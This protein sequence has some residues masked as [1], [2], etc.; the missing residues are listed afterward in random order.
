MFL[1]GVIILVVSLGVVL[2]LK[3][4]ETFTSTVDQPIIALSQC[5]RKMVFPNFSSTNLAAQRAVYDRYSM[6]SNISKGTCNIPMT[7]D[8]TQMNTSTFSVIND[9]NIFYSL[10]RTCLGLS[11]LSMN[12]SGDRVTFVFNTSNESDSKALMYFML[13]NPLF[14]DFSFGVG[15]TS[16]AYFPVFDNKVSRLNGE[17]LQQN[18]VFRYSNY[19]QPITSSMNP[20]VN[21]NNPSITFEVVLPSR[22]RGQ[23]SLFDYFDETNPYILVQDMNAKS[24]R[25][26]V[27]VQVYYL[28]DNIPTSYQNIGKTL[29]SIDSKYDMFNDIDLKNPNNGNEVLLFDKKYVSKYSNDDSRKAKYEFNNNIHVFFKN[30]Q[31]PSFTFSFDINVT[32]DKIR[33]QNFNNAMVILRAYMNNNY[34]NYSYCPGVGHELGGVRNN[35]IMMTLLEFGNKSNNGYNLVI[36]TGKGANCNYPSNEE[37]NLRIPLPYLDD[38][39][40][41]RVVF[42]LTPNEKIAAA[43]WKTIDENNTHVMLGK[44]TYCANDLNLGV[45]FTDKPRT[46]FSIE[47]IVLARNSNFVKSV[48]HVTLGFRNLVAEY[49]TFNN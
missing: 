2:N 43:Y 15:K 14:V 32:R 26:M 49:Q 12:A 21:V 44:N 37:T 31:Q 48:Y 35:N 4:R 39:S 33:S 28:D 25:G 16:V 22:K 36:V 30:F 3:R 45:L 18:K 1:L 29:G 34:G 13:L 9:N 24:Q 20:T 7:N 5:G 46:S 19:T 11:Y 17:T 40:R 42:S 38:S 23:D 41:I 8:G 10:K 47:N 6:M 27:N